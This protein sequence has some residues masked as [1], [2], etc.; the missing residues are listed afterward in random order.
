M[1]IIYSILCILLFTFNANAQSQDESSSDWDFFKVDGKYVEI[2]EKEAAIISISKF[3]YKNDKDDIV[4]IAEFFKCDKPEFRDNFFSVANC[5][6]N[7]GQYQN[8]YATKIGQK[9]ETGEHI[10]LQVYLVSSNN[11]KSKSLVDEA[12][13]FLNLNPIDNTKLGWVTEKDSQNESI[14]FYE[15]R[16]YDAYIG[17]QLDRYI[18]DKSETTKNLTKVLMCKDV[19]EIDKGINF[20]QCDS[21][22]FYRLIDLPNGTYALFSVNLEAKDKKE[23]K[24]KI[25]E[26]EYLLKS[27]K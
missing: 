6:L 13:R 27:S 20:D 5:E 9:E 15:N 10:Y 7:N 12:K 22:H 17:V 11:H 4:K 3:E 1:R 19:Q 18:V 23:V 14:M 8:I 26:L 2:N 25:E 24:E 16:E 21:F